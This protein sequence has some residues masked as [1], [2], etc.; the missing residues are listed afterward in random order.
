ML[1]RNRPT[2][3]AQK[4]IPSRFHSHA[5]SFFPYGKKQG[6]IPLRFKYKKKK[7]LSRYFWKFARKSDLGYKEVGIN[8]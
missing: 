5:S 8:G 4:S 1:S 7:I 2:K 3:A 6:E